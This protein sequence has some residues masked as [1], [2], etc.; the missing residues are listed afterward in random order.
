VEEILDGTVEI[1]DK[2][3]LSFAVGFVYN[4]KE[5]FI[6]FEF[7]LDHYTL[8]I[9]VYSSEDL[10]FAS[11]CIAIVRGVFQNLDNS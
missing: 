5:F 3:V 6:L 4:S 1:N 7:N 11:N 10:E 9:R 2:Q 8:K